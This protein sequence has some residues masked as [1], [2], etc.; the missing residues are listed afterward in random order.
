M[1]SSTWAFWL[2]IIQVIRLRPLTSSSTSGQSRRTSRQPE[3]AVGSGA[4]RHVLRGLGHSPGRRTDGRRHS[5][6]RRPGDSGQSAAAFGAADGATAGGGVSGFSREARAGSG[7]GAG[8]GVSRGLVCSGDGGARLAFGAVSSAFGRGDFGLRRSTVGGGRSGR[9]AAVP[10]GSAAAGGVRTAEPLFDAVEPGGEA[11]FESS[12]A[13]SSSRAQISSSCSRGATAPRISSSPSLTISAARVACTA[14]SRAACEPSRSAT[15]GA[16]STR[17]LP[18]ASG[19]AGDDH[20]VTQPVQEILGE[21]PRILSRFRRPC[22]PPEHAWR[23][24]RRRAH[25]RPRRAGSR[26]CSRGATTAAG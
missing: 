4:R 14:P 6:R 15:S 21:P 18:A 7:A 13:G 9:T 12:A 8:V 22:R 25:R 16:T 3:R 26:G 17:P 19:S 23:R 2:R 11:Q 1:T 5:A 24:R 10:A 20:E